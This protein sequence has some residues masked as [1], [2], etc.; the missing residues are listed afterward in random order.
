MSCEISVRVVLRLLWSRL[1][2]QVEG[3]LVWLAVEVRLWGTGCK[4]KSLRQF[5]NFVRLHGLCASIYDANK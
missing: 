5:S 2:G 1:L 3:L 4:G